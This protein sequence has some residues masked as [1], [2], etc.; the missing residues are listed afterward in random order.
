MNSSARPFVSNDMRLMPALALALVAACGGPYVGRLRGQ[1]VDEQGRPVKG[2]HISLSGPDYLVADEEGKFDGELTLVRRRWHLVRAKTEDSRLGGAASIQDPFQPVAIKMRRCVRVSGRVNYEQLPPSIRE[3][4]LHQWF[5]WPMVA[6]RKAD[7]VIGHIPWSVELKDGAFECFV[8]AG[9][10]DVEVRG[11][12]H[13]LFRE[14]RVTADGGDIDLGVLEAIPLAEHERLDS[15][16]PELHVSD[17]T[18]LADLRGKWVLLLLWDRSCK[19]DLVIRRLVRFHNDPQV[20][21]SRF[22][23]VAVHRDALSDSELEHARTHDHEGRRPEPI[24]FPV[25]V[26]HQGGTFEAYG[27]APG[28]KA[29]HV[30]NAEGKFEFTRWT[31]PVEYVREKLKK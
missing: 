19:N 3:L 17:G 1:V 28:V 21:R 12:H 11:M 25:A 10:Y 13:R 23:I 8:D 9:A 16:A 5:T 7:P 22:A 2:A 30:I 31:E 6:L 15:P 20:D 29:P 14:F 18:K 4:H 24:P 26:D 27:V